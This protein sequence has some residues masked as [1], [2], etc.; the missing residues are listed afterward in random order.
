MTMEYRTLELNII[1]AKDIKNV[2]LFS[3]MDVYAVVTLSGDPLHPQ[4]A[5]THVHKDAGSNPTWNYPVKFSVNESLAKENRL[6]L[7]IKLV[8]DRT[9]GDTVIGTVHV[10][11]RELMDNPGDDGSFRQVSYQVMKQSGKSKGSLNFS[12]KVGEHVPAPAPKAP[13][14][15]QEPVMAYP[16]TGAGSSSMPYGTPHPPPPPP[17]AGSGGYGYPP[18]QAYGGYPPQQGY[19]YPPQAAGYGYPQHQSGYGYPQQPGYGYPPQAQKPKKNKFGMGLGAGLLGGALGGMLIGD[20]VSDAADYDAGYDAGFDDAGG[21][22][23]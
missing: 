21:F 23:F 12:Y 1:S 17:V 20:M 11:L 9:L 6:S 22:D 10:P 2:N 4:G 18:Q 16:P 8:S 3:K 14:T 7:E 15:G 5:T 13:K 19:G